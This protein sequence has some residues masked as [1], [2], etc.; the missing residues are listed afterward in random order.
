VHA[1]EESA[2]RKSLETRATSWL[3]WARRRY[4][5]AETFQQDLKRIE[6]F[7]AEHGYPRA[8]VIEAAVDKREKDVAFAR[9]G[10]RRTAAT[11]G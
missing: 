10:R 11:C 2:L 3:P 5:D 6:T 4:F 1:V 7:Y 9:R 8:R